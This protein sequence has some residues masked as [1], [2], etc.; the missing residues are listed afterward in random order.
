MFGNSTARF[1]MKTKNSSTEGFSI[2]E[3]M[4]TVAI[5]GVITGIVV[6]KYGA[7]NNLV[8]LKNQAFQI[9]LDIRAI[10]TKALSAQGQSGT[11][12]RYAYGVYFST[13]A[14][15]SYILFA[16]TNGNNVYNNGEEID[17]R[18]LDSRFEISSLC[19]GSICNLTT[20][21]VTFKRPNFDAIM[22][23]GAVSS[24]KVNVLPKNSTGVT[25]RTITIN[26]AGQISVQ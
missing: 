23:N 17:T 25:A 4:I 24:G 19:N 10:Q 15:D 14:K 1:N 21:S 5:I 2:L 11:D 7:F 22:N 6:L 18:K 16:D 13:S 8:L 20:L 3:V 12:F 9:A 26:P